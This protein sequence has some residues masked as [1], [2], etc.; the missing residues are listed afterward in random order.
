M[1][2]R[3]SCVLALL[4]CSTGTLYT[5]HHCLFLRTRSDRYHLSPHSRPAFARLENRHTLSQLI[6]PFAVEKLTMGWRFD[7]NIISASLLYFHIQTTTR[8]SHSL[9]YTTSEHTQHPLHTLNK[10]KQLLSRNSPWALRRCFPPAQF[11]SYSHVGSRRIPLRPCR[12]G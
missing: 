2:R 12:M 7:S 5:H 6:Q 10:G 11:S 8:I 3:S 1:L 4:P 9:P